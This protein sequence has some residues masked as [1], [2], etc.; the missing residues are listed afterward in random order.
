MTHHG[1]TRGLGY[2]FARK[3]NKDGGG[4]KKKKARVFYS[5]G[6]VKVPPPN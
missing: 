1:K 2:R 6:Q 4:K 5:L 3:K